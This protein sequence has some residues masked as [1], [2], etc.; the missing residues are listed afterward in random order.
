MCISSSNS[1]VERVFNALTTLLTDRRLSMSHETM[2]DCMLIAGNSSVWTEC[3]KEEI[4]EVA[5]EKYMRVKRRITKI[6]APA[7]KERVAMSSGSE[8]EVE[9]NS[10]SGGDESNDELT[11]SDSEDS[12]Y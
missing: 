4:L 10:D 7:P 8:S 9:S 6:D 5:V 3:E 1:S 11:E 12:L 2:E